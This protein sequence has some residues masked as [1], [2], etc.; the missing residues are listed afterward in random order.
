MFL[1]TQK[2]RR[3]S[4]RAGEESA[5]PS[6]HSK[7]I[8]QQKLTFHSSMRSLEPVHSSSVKRANMALRT[9]SL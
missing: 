3:M 7:I 1:Y 4:V 2:S 5:F 8:W 9:A 6:R